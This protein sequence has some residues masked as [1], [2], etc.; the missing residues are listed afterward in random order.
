MAASALRASR[1]ATAFASL[2]RGEAVKR[3]CMPHHGCVVEPVGSEQSRNV[4]NDLDTGKENWSGPGRVQRG[5][6]SV[7]VGP[8]RGTDAAWLNGR[9]IL[10]IFS[11]RGALVSSYI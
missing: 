1:V 10:E 11:L 4:L 9:A 2:E 6:V 5:S 3:H 8:S 7:H